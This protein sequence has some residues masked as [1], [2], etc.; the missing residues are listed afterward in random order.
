MAEWVYMYMQLENWKKN[1][2]EIEREK[3]YYIGLVKPIIAFYSAHYPNVIFNRI[4]WHTISVSKAHFVHVIELRRN[5]NKAAAKK[6]WTSCWCCCYL[7]LYLKVLVMTLHLFDASCIGFP[8]Q[9]R[10]WLN[11]TRFRTIH[12]FAPRMASNATQQ[13]ALIFAIY[14]T[15][16]T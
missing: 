2:R 5:N 13:K 16:I 7:D 10:Y 3:G 4:N 11:F 1:Q 8:S 6:S 14:L 9:Y 15:L 12:I